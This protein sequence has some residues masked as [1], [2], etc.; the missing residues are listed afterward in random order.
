LNKSQL[1]KEQI[2]PMKNL[3]ILILAL[4]ICQNIFG[5]EFSFPI[6]FEDAIGNKI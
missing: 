4:I 3:Y 6:V 1:A 2:A 5:Q